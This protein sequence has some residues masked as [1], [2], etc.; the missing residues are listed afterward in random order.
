MLSAQQI[1]SLL[2]STGSL[3]ARLE[4]IAKKPL[5][6]QV[7]KEGYETLDFSTKQQLGLACHKPCIGWVRKVA[8]YGTHDTPWV[9]ATSVFPI[10][11][12]TGKGKRLK[13]LGDTPIGYVL[14]ARH[15]QLPFV[16]T[17]DGTSRKTVYDWE[18]RRILIQENFG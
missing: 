14:F 12:L 18:G 13:H 5:L 17:F 7:I 2:H 6:V 11:S 9:Y 4:K 10:N 15:R 1:H 16:R 3:T 8:L